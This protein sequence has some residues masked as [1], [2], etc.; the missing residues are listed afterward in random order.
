MMLHMY[1]HSIELGCVLCH[2]ATLELNKGSQ[3]RPAFEQIVK[4]S[5]KDRTR[6]RPPDFILT[7][8]LGTSS[9][10]LHT[11]TFQTPIF[12]PSDESAIMSHAVIN[13]LAAETRTALLATVTSS[14]L[15]A[16]FDYVEKSSRGTEPSK[17]PG[18]DSLEYVTHPNA[19]WLLPEDEGSDAEG[20]RRGVPY[21]SRSGRSRR[22]R[23]RGRG[24]KTHAASPAGTDAPEPE[25]LSSDVEPPQ[26][27]TITE[28]SYC[29]TTD[30]QPR[31]SE[32]PD[33]PHATTNEDGALVCS[34]LSLRG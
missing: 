23:R 8:L 25:S 27:S 26:A 1:E 5:S 19:P 6:S 4:V 12:H 24:P 16:Y 32:A 7:D 11:T 31:F 29:T 34:A 21:G 18:D 13:N 30:V 15:E 22:G 14:K 33:V 10:S 2:G 28:A 20:P 17:E 9:L 3:W